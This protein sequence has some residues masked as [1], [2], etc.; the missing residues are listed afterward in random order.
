MGIYVLRTKKG[1]TMK[2]KLISELSERQEELGFMLRM[3]NQLTDFTRGM[4]FGEYQATKLIIMDLED[5][6]S[7]YNLTTEVKFNSLKKKYETLLNS[8]TEKFNKFDMNDKS[9]EKGNLAGKMTAYS[10][11]IWGLMENDTP[12]PLLHEEITANKEEVWKN[13]MESTVIEL[14]RQV[15]ELKKHLGVE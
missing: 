14:T 6:F 5:S 7:Y 4:A 1:D 8:T 10:K 11:A 2:L 12:F 13:Q 9:Y 15:K 3:D